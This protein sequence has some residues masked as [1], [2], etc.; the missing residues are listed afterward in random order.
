MRAFGGQAI[1]N[2]LGQ[3]SAQS[4]FDKILNPEFCRLV[5]S[6]AELHWIANIMPPIMRIETRTG[7][8]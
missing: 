6:L 5:N 8:A 7:Q 3:Q 1:G 2:V 4:N